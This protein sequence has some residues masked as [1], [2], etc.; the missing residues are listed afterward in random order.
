MKI[1]LVGG[2][3]RD[4]LLGKPTKDRDWVVVGATP[5]H[6]LENGYQQVGRDFPVF[7]HPQTK[8]E[9]ALARTE[10][11]TGKGYAGFIC[12]AGQDV[13]LEED[14]QRR[15][16]TINA[17]AEDSD[18]TVIDPYGGLSDLQQ[19]ILR[20]VSPAFSEDPLRIARGTLSCALRR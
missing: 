18:G 14:L 13:T 1:Y 9:Y 16:L 17:M 11:K 20:H 19:K 6:L 2:A 8:E 10:R 12:H 7:L 15:D 4:K 5:G 3:V